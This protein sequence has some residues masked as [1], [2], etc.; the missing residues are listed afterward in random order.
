MFAASDLR[1]DEKCNPRQ[2]LWIWKPP[3]P[4]KTYC[5]GADA[6]EGSDSRESDYCAAQVVEVITCE[7]VAEYHARNVDPIAFAYVLARLGV[8]YG[9]VM[10]F[11]KLVPEINTHGSTT[12]KVLIEVLGYPNI[13]RTRVYNKEPGRKYGVW[14]DQF[15]WRTVAQN[16]DIPINQSRSYFRDNPGIINSTRLMKEVEH[17]SYVQRPGQ[18]RDKAGGEGKH[19]DDLVWAWMLALYGRN[20]AMKELSPGQLDRSAQEKE[21]PHQWVWDRV[22][23]MERELD[24]AKACGDEEYDPSRVRYVE[25]HYAESALW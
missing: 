10:G 11:A 1:L 12:C 4:H 22:K 18:M 5:I 13:W 6:A 21:N 14:T 9:G 24:W 23:E 15:G 7:Q 16:R 20:Y 25:D 19:K 8:L 2:P 17:F 3:D